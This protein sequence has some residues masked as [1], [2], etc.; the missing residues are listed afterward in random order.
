MH[1]VRHFEEEPGRQ[2][3]AKLLT[4]DEARR[5]ATNLA[6]VARATEVATSLALRIEI[7]FSKEYPPTK[8]VGW[9][10]FSVIPGRMD[11]PSITTNPRKTEN[12]IGVGALRSKPFIAKAAAKVPFLSIHASCPRTP[13]RF[14]CRST[15]IMV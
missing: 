7:A 5:T 10:A 1:Q 6:R 8:S 2:S 12:G 14:P 4:K 11:L 3:A 9:S 13:A 15:Y